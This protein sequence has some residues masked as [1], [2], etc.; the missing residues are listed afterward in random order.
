MIK[1]TQDL[2]DIT[3]KYQETNSKYKYRVLVCAGGGCVSADCHEVKDALLQSLKENDLEDQVLV[4]ETGCIGTCNLGP[5]M[6]VM[7]EEVFYTRLK[8]K[9]I[10]EIVKS[11]LVEGNI[12]VNKTYFDMGALKRVPYLNEISFFKK[13][14]KIALRNCGL[15]DYS[16]IDEYI[17]NDGYKA[18]LKV[19]Q[20]MTQEEV[21]QEITKS[22]LRG[23]GGA[24]FPA[25]IKWEAGRKAP[26]DQK[27]LI[28]NA[29]EGDPGAFMDRSIIEGDPHTIIEGMMIGGYAIGANKG[30]CYIRAEYPI[31]VERLEYALKQAREAGILGKNVFGTDFAFDIEIRIGAGAFV[32]GEETALMASVEGKRGEPKQKPPFPFQKGLFQKPTIINNVETLANIPPIIL[33]GSEWFNGFGTEKSKGTK[34][35]ALAGDIVN[36]GLVEVPMGMTLREIVYDLGG[37]VP[38]K[39][40]F[41]AAQMGG[42]SGGCI[43]SD[44]L[45]TP[46]DFD[47][48]AQLGAIMGSGGLIVMNEN[49]C[50]VDVAKFFMEFVQDE[51]CGKCVP[52]RAGTKAILE[53]LDRI[54]EGNG[55]ENDIE[56]MEKLCENIKKTAICGLGQTAPNPVLSTLRYFRDE[57]EEHIQNKPCRAGGNTK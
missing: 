40:A 22:G 2:L 10:P 51:S 8:P 57:Y 36:T 30:F 41:K 44:D 46:V 48:L 23:R 15:I 7:P 43:V 49:N 53:V 42:P 47:S 3:K 28:C 5:V 50:M 12:L 19:L 38:K 13:Q 11:H 25:G 32:C 1:S 26:G 31:A 4:S 16:S 27:Y 24:G 21:T 29:D 33:N 52:C 55:Q 6:V 9:D 56:L 20:E 18:V 39:K 14:V 17:A 45:D 37:G 35:F 54:L 34:V